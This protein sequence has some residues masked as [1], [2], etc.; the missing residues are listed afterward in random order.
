MKRSPSALM[1]NAQLDTYVSAHE[2]LPIAVTFV[3]LKLEAAT[4]SIRLLHCAQ[5]P[6]VLETNP[7]QAT[8][9]SMLVQSDTDVKVGNGNE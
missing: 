5:H 3:A 8:I 7:L 6:T 1:R 4:C 2:G 9:N